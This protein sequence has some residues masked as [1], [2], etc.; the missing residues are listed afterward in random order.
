MALFQSEAAQ[1][2]TQALLA[3][4]DKCLERP[5][6]VEDALKQLDPCELAHDPEYL[7]Q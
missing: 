3:I 7:A 6:V 4:P 1:R 2:R 5:V